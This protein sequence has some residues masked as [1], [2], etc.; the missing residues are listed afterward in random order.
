MMTK[1]R[2]IAAFV[3]GCG[4]ISLFA[5]AALA[6]K[7]T[8]LPKD[9]DVKG[10]YVGMRG[11]YMQCIL[12]GNP[13][14]V[15]FDQKSKVKVTGTATADFLDKGMFVQFKGTFDRH[16]KGMEPIKEF[17]I[18]T[19]GPNNPTGAFA[20]GGVGANAFE[21]Q[22]NATKKKGPPPATSMY[23]IAGRITAAH[24][25][26]LSIDCG[27]MKVRAEVAPDAKVKLEAADPSWASPGDIVKV[28]GSVDQP[29]RGVALAKDVSINLA[30]Q[31]APRRRAHPAAVAEKT[32]SKTIDKNT[33]KSAKTADKTD[34][35]TDK[36]AKGDDAADK[37]D[38][39]VTEKKGADKKGADPKAGD[40]KAADTK[41]TAAKAADKA[42]DAK[43]PD[44][45]ADAAK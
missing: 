35:T 37:D 11:G 19:P 25:N 39:K 8:P 6:Q 14:L 1:F 17:V 24:N 42:A 7:A 34:K 29:P 5:H 38:K 30:N 45:K 40:A 41:A 4:M 15:R 12:N 32:T 44:E 13:T 2:G 3:F 16:G 36:T 31:L 43:K 33:D 22:Q 23:E 18:F 21:E 28:N 20:D 27:N 10:E 26:L 9:F